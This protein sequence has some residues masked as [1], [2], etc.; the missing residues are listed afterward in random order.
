MRPHTPIRVFFCITVAIATSSFTLGQEKAPERGFRPSGSYALSDIETIS[1]TSGNMILKVPLASLPPGRGGLSASLSLLYNSKLY[2]SFP[3]STYINHSFY[4]VT[5][6]KKSQAGGWR[7]GYKYELYGEGRFG[8]ID[9]M[10]EINPCSFTAYAAKFALLTPD[11]AKHDLRLANHTD[12]D[13]FHNVWQDGSPAC[14]GGAPDNGTLNYYTTDG[15]F[16][17]LEVAHDSD[18]NPLNNAW[19][20]FL[21]DGGR[22]TGGNAN[23]RI[24]DRNN[25]FIEIINYVL[26]N[27]HSATKLQDELNRSIVIEYG[28]AANQDNI[29]VSGYNGATLTTTIT[30]ADVVVHK[31]YTREVG[32]PFNLPATWRSVSQITLPS[33]AGSLTYIFGYNANGSNPTVG[34][35]ELSSIT[36]PSG[37]KATYTYAND[38]QNNIYSDSVLLNRPTQKQLLYRAEYDGTTVS[39]SVCES[40]QPCITETWTYGMEYVNTGEGNLGITST[41]TSPDGGVTT[42]H[43]NKNEDGTINHNGLVY[44]S[45]SPDGTVTERYWQSN[46]PYST[47]PPYVFNE[48]H[49]PK[50]EFTSVPNPSGTPT[51]TAIKEYNYDKNG[52]ITRVA[53][54]DWV[55][56]ANVPRNGQGRPYAVPSGVT[57]KSVT[58]NTYYNPTPDASN[59]TTYDSDSFHI[60]GSPRLHVLLESSEV[61]DG[62]NTR[63]SRTE[64]SYD[65]TATVGVVAYPIGNPTQQRRWDNTKGSFSSPP[66]TSANGVITSSTYDSYGNPLATT[67]AKGTQTQLSY[68]PVN[69]YLGLYA[70]VTKVAYGTSVQRHTTTIY[71][72]YTGVVK[73][74]KDED[75]N[76][77][78]VT[79]YDDLA[80]TTLVQRA[81]GKTEE[82]NTLTEYSDADRRVIVRSDRDAVGDGKLISIQHYDQLG[83]IRLSRQ[84]EDSGTQSPLL[85]AD[86]IK[87]QTRYIVNNPCQPNNDP[88]C[89]TTNKNDLASY[90]LVSN[91]YRATTSG[92][93]GSEATM[94]WKRTR[95]N[96]AG[97]VVEVKTFGGASLPGPWGANS[98]STGTIS[99]AFDAQFKTVTDQAGKARK[100]AIDGLGRLKEVY[101]DPS[102][103]NYLTSYTYDPLSNLVKVDQGSQYRY[104]KYDSLSRLRRAR[105]PEQDNYSSLNE[106]DPVT[107]NSQWSMGYQYDDNGNLTQ[108]T[109]S[110]GITST[111]VYDALNRN[112]TVDYS[113][114]TTINPDITRFYDG[115]TNGK[116]RFWYS[117]AGGSYSVGA[118][119]EHTA[120]D[121][122]DA[123]GRPS[124]QR[125]LFKLNGAWG[126]TYQISRAYNRAGSVTNQTYPSGRTVSYTYDGA[127]RTASFTGN[128]GDGTNRTYSN[129]TLYS[130][131]GGLSREQ[132]GTN[133]PLYHKQRYTNRGQLWDMRLSTVD[134]ETN[135]NRGVIINYYSLANLVEGGTGTDTNG[136]LYLQQHWVPHND[137]IS[138]YTVHQQA[139]AYDTLN[140]LTW[141]GEYLNG[142]TNTGS[143]HY[144]Y[145][146]WGNRKIDPITWGTGINNKQFDVNPANNR[147]AVPSGQSGTMS[148]DYAGNLITDSYTGAGSRVYDAENRMISAQGINQGNWQYYTYNADGQRVRRKVDGVETLQVYGMDGELLA[149]YA[150][151][152]AAANS[153]REYGYRNGQLLVTASNLR[154]YWTAD[155]N[156]GTTA[157]D[158]SG[159]SNIGTLTSGAGW[160]VGQSGSAVS[161]DGANDY[162]QVGAASSLVMTSA[163]SFSAWIYPTG[164]GSDATYGGTILVKEGE[165]V[166]ARYPNGTIQ[167]GFANSNP[168][169]NFVN[170]GYV[171]ALNQWTHIAVTYDNGTVKTYANGTLVHTFNGSG[172]IG[173]AITSQNDFRIGGR[174][175]IS[176]HFQGRIDEVRVYNRALTP[177]EVSNLPSGALNASNV[178]WL[179]ADHLGTPRMILDNSGSLASVKRHDYLPFGE[180]LFAGVGGRTTQNGYTGD[181]VRQKFTSKER[182]NETGLDYFGARY[183][184]GIQGRFTGTDPYDI[185]FERQKTSDPEEADDLFRDYIGQPQH[186]NRY[187]YVLNNPLRYVDPD[188]LMKYTIVLLGKTITVNIS[189]DIDEKEQEQIKQMI[190]NVVDRINKDADKL[191]P[192]QIKH[193]NSMNG[194][195]VTDN[196][197]Y[198]HMDGTTFKIKPHR[199]LNSTV[200]S[201]AGDT[202]HDSFHAS[203][204][205]RG[206]D[207]VGLAAER[208]ASA[209]AA[210]VG[211]KLGL[212]ERVLEVLRAD[213]ITGHG[214]P[215]NNST[216]QSPKKKP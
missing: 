196:I 37:A 152:A 33:Q 172:S 18:S 43:F 211:E 204:N 82:T 188:G 206:K 136:N 5:N 72:F 64:M 139:Y 119:V 184:A 114:T 122:Y 185:N 85:E 81:D 165:Y 170:T 210:A 173:D 99:T 135:W 35:G 95:S 51:Q 127:G 27:G 11:G 207:S 134:D 4:E 76:V 140:R 102:G 45:V 83:R 7:Y 168:G 3:S 109:D 32:T 201:L 69:G 38:N 104:F 112:T 199:V 187:A 14:S 171:A 49:Y 89:L 13:G 68:G 148:Y 46:I 198:S 80:R 62:N 48:T 120:I 55:P 74:S 47:S 166:I 178:N 98:T 192:D 213:A 39:N 157:A 17:R 90:Q 26:P 150:S 44:K 149:E 209:F 54:Y 121:S 137:Q 87:V 86:G 75:N 16:L 70:T 161:L 29:T 181:A 67:D 23:Q 182:D 131:W 118:T 10:G 180:E 30:W 115:A 156:T 123:L 9:E 194:I 106:Y 202:I 162:V 167:W 12:G 190:D 169:W 19:T 132:F 2:D 128:L 65:Y 15:T 138:A 1:T 193:I 56:Y 197:P 191:T 78:T 146:R 92:N 91:P 58:V 100:S 53:A 40:P 22:V 151:D 52:N 41:I 158:S 103:V 208:E 147:L 195:K 101:E 129:I 25:N 73:E 177:S 189:D 84:L 203:Q 125:Q 215:K 133:I 21:P 108:K 107:T 24:W 59:S 96:V 57:P 216:K 42:E 88:Q 94:G 97:R 61:Q 31:A 145:D 79:G 212:D 113:D 141:A 175:V 164:A 163:A 105:N 200:D 111:L 8:G 144:Q 36:L 160:G 153:Q 63:F 110:R 117:Y 6:L 176:H 77:T 20:L 93:A 66:I 183:Y 50:Y 159:N 71:D 126:P 34:W 155:E 28:S 116:G 205:R 60:A 142:V 214:P 186:W 179:V 154:G 174:Q 124:V 130:P 143:Q